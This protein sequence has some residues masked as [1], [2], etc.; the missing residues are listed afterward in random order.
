MAKPYYWQLK[1]SVAQN[2]LYLPKGGTKYHL[3][4][5]GLLQGI[6]WCRTGIRYQECPY[7]FGDDIQSNRAA[8]DF[9]YFTAKQEGELDSWE[10]IKVRREVD[11]VVEGHY[12]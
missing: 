4:G 8:G 1:L 7:L 2:K 5:T 9:L 6:G 12:D 3:F 11:H 10:Q